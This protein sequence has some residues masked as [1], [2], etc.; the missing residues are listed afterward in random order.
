MAKKSKKVEEKEKFKVFMTYEE[1]RSGGEAKDLDNRW[2]DREDEVIEFSP[3][4]LYAAAQGNYWVETIEVEF[5]PAKYIGEKIDVVVVRYS[6]GDTFGQTIGHWNVVGAWPA[7]TNEADN[8]VKAIEMDKY[9]GD[10]L[11]WNGYFAHRGNVELH[12][13]RLEKVI[14]AHEEIK[15][16]RRYYHY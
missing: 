14:V 4:S 11:P 1:S 3:I 8:I 10:Y 5:D 9:V 12:T 6:D 2:S 13:F 7:E 16:A 15:P